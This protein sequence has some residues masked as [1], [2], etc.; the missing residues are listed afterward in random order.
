MLILCQSH[1]GAWVWI[2]DLATMLGSDGIDFAL[3]YMLSGARGFLWL[4][5]IVPGA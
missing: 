5:P 3:E 2:P 4:R 1:R